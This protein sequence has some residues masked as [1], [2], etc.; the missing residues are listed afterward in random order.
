MS[1]NFSVCQTTCGET[2]SV[3]TEKVC[4]CH[5]I[6]GNAKLFLGCRWLNKTENECLTETK[7]QIISTKIDLPEKEQRIEKEREIKPEEDPVK[8]ESPIALV[9]APKENEVKY[10]TGNCEKLEDMDNWSCVQGTVIFR[11]SF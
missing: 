10:A 5:R 9:E 4:A 11:T 1:I 8:E 7:K 3:K 6:V 2:G